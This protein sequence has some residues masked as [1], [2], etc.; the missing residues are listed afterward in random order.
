M[1]LLNWARS[2]AQGFRH[3]DAFCARDGGTHQAILQRK[4][5]ILSK[6]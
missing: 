1:T 2:G 5:V 4:V 3:A 6:A